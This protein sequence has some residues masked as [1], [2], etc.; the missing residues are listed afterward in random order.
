[1][2]EIVSFYRAPLVCDAD[3]RIGCGSRAKPALLELEGNPLVK[4]AWLNREGTVIAI[5]WKDKAETQSVAK[6]VFDKFSIVFTELSHHEAAR[7]RQTFRTPNLWFRA[8]AVDELSREEAR[9]IAENAVK[10]ALEGELITEVEATYLKP[11][12]EEYFRNELVKVRNYEQL[13]EDY[14]N[15]FLLDV[16]RI[17]EM[18]LGE[19]RTKNIMG[20]LSG[21]RLGRGENCCDQAT[22]GCLPT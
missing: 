3:P 13:I 18:Y 9:T 2:S 5:V 4:E 10:T 11:A 8:A 1:M 16:Y 14:H 12:I 21:G 19:E 22:A 7:Y 15:R 17:V 6:P 20:R